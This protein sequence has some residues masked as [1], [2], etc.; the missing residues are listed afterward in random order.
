MSSCCIVF[1]YTKI[2]YIF[3]VAALCDLRKR[4]FIN[5]CIIIIIMKNNV[6]TNE[7]ICRFHLKS[8]P[9]L[10]KRSGLGE[11][12]VVGL[13]TLSFEMHVKGDL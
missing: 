5:S 8:N 9:C 6:Q 13:T 10:T 1:L 11:E 3:L 4:R 12:L 7:P 2:V